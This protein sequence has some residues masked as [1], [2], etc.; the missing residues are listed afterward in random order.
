MERVLLVNIE[1]LKR[2]SYIDANVHN[3]TIRTAVGFVQDSIIE[4]VIGTCLF[5][6]LKELIATNEICDPENACYK[7]LLDNYLFKIFQ[8]AVKADLA[9]PLAMKERNAGIIRA[10]DETFTQVSLKDIN[11]YKNEFESKAAFYQKRAIDFLRCNKE[12]FG[13]ICS[14]GGCCKRAPYNIRLNT[15]LNLSN[16]YKKGRLLW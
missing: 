12:C 11:L 1:T 4:N 15:P 9:I 2:D 16:T 5:N 8:Y 13:N 14:C 6:K 7:E 3:D 10:N